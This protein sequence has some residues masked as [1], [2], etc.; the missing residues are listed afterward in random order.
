MMDDYKSD[1]KSIYNELEEY[2]INE[3]KKRGKLFELMCLSN[4][5]MIYINALIQICTN[6]GKDYTH[7]IK[8]NPNLT[9]NDV[10]KYY[11]DIEKYDDEVYVYVSYTIGDHYDI[12]SDNRIEFI[13]SM[14]YYKTLRISD[15]LFM[16]NKYLSYEL[17]K[18]KYSDIISNNEYICNNPN[19]NFIN[20][21]MSDISALAKHINNFN[22]IYNERLEEI[23][24]EYKSI[25]KN[26]INE[27]VSYLRYE[28][29]LDNIGLFNNCNIFTYHN[30]YR[31]KSLTINNVVNIIN[32]DDVQD[33]YILYLFMHSNI[34][35]QD[36]IA[37]NLHK[38][39][40]FYYFASNRNCTISDIVNNPELNWIYVTDL[41]ALNKHEYFYYEFKFAD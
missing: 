5:P 8:D 32:N 11:Y 18:L 38:N 40:Y 19:G 3:S 24:I 9:I 27:A 15:I 16:R 25:L 23:I 6:C 13:N 31:N 41:L 30:L 29:I 12:F 26:E 37:N 14:F 21:D 20:Y 4:N 36:I 34:T 7:Y 2:M 10:E 22:G 39:T 35:L 17:Y 33:R 28:F 1:Y